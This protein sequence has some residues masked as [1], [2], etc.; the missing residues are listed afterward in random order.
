MPIPAGRMVIPASI[1]EHRIRLSP[2]AAGDPAHDGAVERDQ[3][4]SDLPREPDSGQPHQGPPPAQPRGHSP[5]T[6]DAGTP[7]RRRPSPSLPANHA[8]PSPL[9]PLSEDA[10]LE[11]GTAK[12]DGQAPVVMS[13]TAHPVMDGYDLSPG[14]HGHRRKNSSPAH[15]MLR[16]HQ[17]QSVTRVRQSI[18]AR[19]PGDLQKDVRTNRK[20]MSHRTRECMN[21]CQQK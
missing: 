6:S 10:R 18:R 3:C 5:M 9:M 7:R 11:S 1:T 21:S 19:R 2:T 14:Q 20:V 13:K 4:R 15:L 17:A 16:T 12:V 8:R